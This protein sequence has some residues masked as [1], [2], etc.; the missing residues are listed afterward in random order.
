MRELIRVDEL[1]PGMVITRITQQNGPVAIQKSGLVSSVAMVHGLREMGVLEVEIDPV[2]TVQIAPTD[3]LVVESDIITAANPADKTTTTS[4]V[5]TTANNAASTTA[6][7]GVNTAA[8]ITEQSNNSA[9]QVR[10]KTATQA[11]L[12]GQY[13]NNIY[14]S[15]NAISE[16]FSRSLLL[17]SAQHLP[18]MW[19]YSWKYYAKPLGICLILITGGGGLGYSATQLPSAIP[20]WSFSHNS[21]QTAQNNQTAQNT[22]IA[23]DAKNALNTEGTSQF[24]PVS[25]LQ[26][27]DTIPAS[28]LP[29]TSSTTKPTSQASEKAEET[30]QTPVGTLVQQ[31]ASEPTGMVERSASEQQPALAQAVSEGGEVLNESQ[32]EEKVNISPD[33]L[34]KFN[35]AVRELDS[36]ASQT[37]EEPPTSVTVHN[38]IQMIHQLPVRVL[39]RLPSMSFTAHMY[40]SQASDR[41]VRVNGQQL[42]ERE[43]IGDQVQIVNIE[44]QQVV[45]KFENEVFAMAALTDW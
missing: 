13:D 33:L 3:E 44:A 12:R 40:A 26:S 8:N 34:A 21:E 35:Q 45:L 30:A 1:I 4:A 11:L 15:N 7:S 9:T 5:N 38:D 41:W 23:K 32:P 22:Q 14:S 24:A 29:T 37:E 18:S 43:W 25:A 42:F 10:T 19:S 20:L 31:Q 27:V 16:Q 2:Q 39:T 36:Q 28:N 17:P 6:Y